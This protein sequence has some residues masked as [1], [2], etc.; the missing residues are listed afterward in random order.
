MINSSLV[1][2]QNRVRLYWTNIPNIAQPK[3]KNIVLADILEDGV[4]DRSKSYY[5]DAHY[6]C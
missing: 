1:S 5:L 3:D 2:A 6:A 4:T